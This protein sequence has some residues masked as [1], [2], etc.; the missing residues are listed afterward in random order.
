M[1]T[2]KIAKNMNLRK[3]KLIAGFFYITFFIFLI[4]IT[5]SYIS[6]NSFNCETDTITD[7]DQNTYETVAIGEQCWMAEN[8]KTSKYS[9]GERIPYPESN[10]EWRD[11]GNNK[12]GAYSCYEN[13]EENCEIYGALYN[14]YAVSEG[15]CP[16]GWYVPTDEDWKE[17]E[18]HLGV[19]EEELN[20]LYWRGS[21]ATDLVG[22]AW[23]WKNEKIGERKNFNSTGFTAVPAGYRLSNG[24]YSWIGQRANFWTSTIKASGWRRTL[25]PE[26]SEG[27]RRTAAAKNIGFSVRCLK[28]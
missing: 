11:T 18:R 6:K 16:E 2:G 4:L 21:I 7:T 9:D 15:L 14:V 24:I 26:I 12:T 20:R 13:E 3:N 19:E 8:L 1:F 27:V 22:K 25:I 5:N 10:T 23:L 17:L 28:K